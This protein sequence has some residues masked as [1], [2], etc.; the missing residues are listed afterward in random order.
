[1]QRFCVREAHADATV[2]LHML[3]SW[4]G[5][6]TVVVWATLLQ[7]C[8]LY[9]AARHGLAQLTQHMSFRGTWF[10]LY[11][12]FVRRDAGYTSFLEIMGFD[13]CFCGGLFL[14]KNTGCLLLP[15]RATGLWYTPMHDLHITER[16]GLEV[17]VHAEVNS[18]K[19]LSLYLSSLGM[20]RTDGRPCLVC[21]SE[22]NPH[23]T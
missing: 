23:A 5:L 10:G 12:Y 7:G 16:N 22:K 19:S 8:E 4:T 17:Q 1:M 20:L 9:P 2:M 15:A 13:A 3:I 14:G 18:N 11:L 6:L 21:L